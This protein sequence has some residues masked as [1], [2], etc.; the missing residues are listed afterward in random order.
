MI[1]LGL[2]F[3]LLSSPVF[4]D[5]LQ[6]MADCMPAAEALH[7]TCDFNLSAGGEPVEDATFTVT[8]TMPSM[9]MAHN[10][11]PADIRRGEA[12]G[13]YSADLH[14]EMLGDWILTLDITRPHRDRIVLNYTFDDA[15][16]ADGAKGHS[17]QHSD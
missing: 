3:A 17:H 16:P 6:A 1:R 15:P 2:A 10:I 14:L 13:S 11:P 9:P 12:P 7:F 5:R 8:P 4:A